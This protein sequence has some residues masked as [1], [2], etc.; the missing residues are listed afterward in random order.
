MMIYLLIC[1]AF[2]CAIMSS[3]TRLGAYQKV[4]IDFFDEV[5]L[6]LLMTMIAP[7]MFFIVVSVYIKFF[8][9]AF[10]R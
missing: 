3:F 1:L 6:V 5:M 9:K 4:R 7:L 10:R 2:S 8:V